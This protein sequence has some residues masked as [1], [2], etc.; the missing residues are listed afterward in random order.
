MMKFCVKLFLCFHIF[1]LMKLS[2]S[3]D[4]AVSVAVWIVVLRLAF[5]SCL[6]FSLAAAGVSL[7]RVAL[8]ACVRL[9][10]WLCFAA[11]SRCCCYGDASV[12][13]AWM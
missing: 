6:R 12:W 11:F 3:L 7:L 4:L 1:G 8:P 9:C 2:Y 5:G 10:I 13:L